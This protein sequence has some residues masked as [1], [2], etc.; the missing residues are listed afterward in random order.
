MNERDLARRLQ[1]PAVGTAPTSRGECPVARSGTMSSRGFIFRCATL[2]SARSASAASGFGSGGLPSTVQI[3]RSYFV[4][5]RCRIYPELAA[6]G[7]VSQRGWQGEQGT[8]CQPRAADPVSL[9][10]AHAGAPQKFLSTPFSS[11]ALRLFSSHTYSMK[12][13]SGFH[14]HTRLAV[15]GFVN[16]FRILDGEQDFQRV[17]DLC[18]CA[19]RRAAHPN[20]S[21]PASSICVS[22]TRPTVSIPSVSPFQW[23]I[24]GRGN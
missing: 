22:F 10:K 15:H 13:M 19:P 17:V 9:R 18:G 2:V 21:M 14:R 1:D 11:G 3:E 24:D 16:A 4:I 8:E 20:A 12:R 7:A 23:P 5:A 6:R